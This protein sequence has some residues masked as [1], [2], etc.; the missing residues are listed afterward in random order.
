[1]RLYETSARHKSGDLVGK[2]RFELLSELVSEVDPFSTSRETVTDFSTKS[3]GSPF[4]SLKVSEVI[5]FF[6]SVKMDFMLHYPELSC[7]PA[8]P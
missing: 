6:S 8:K 3:S 5:R 2:E 1:M 4:A 7:R